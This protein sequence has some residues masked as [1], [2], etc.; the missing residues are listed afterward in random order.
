MNNGKFNKENTDKIIEAIRTGVPKRYAAARAGI[1]EETFYNWQRPFLPDGET[2]NPVY[3][4]E[5]AE[6]VKRAEAD[7]VAANMAVIQRAGRGRK[8][9]RTKRLEDGTEV[10]EEFDLEKPQWTAAAWYLE[11]RHRDDFALKREI[12]IED[13]DGLFSAKTINIV[14]K[15]PDKVEDINLEDGSDTKPEAS[16][17]DSVTG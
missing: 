7:C 6:A 5:F 2:P 15:E 10:I 16:T 1:T 9:K 3:S 4:A 11:R 13:K 17:G 8:G 12:E 14:V